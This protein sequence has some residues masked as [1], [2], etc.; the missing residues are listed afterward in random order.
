MY[1]IRPFQSSVFTSELNEQ[2][3][4]LIL[5]GLSI[6]DSPSLYQTI[7]DNRMFYIILYTYLYYCRSYAR[8]KKVCGVYNN[9]IISSHIL[10]FK[11]I[12]HYFLCWVRNAETNIIQVSQNPP[13]SFQSKKE[14]IA[15][16][17]HNNNKNN[18]VV[19]G[20]TNFYELGMA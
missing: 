14:V 2:L 17:T 12:F 6:L 3:I 9:F 15:C 4:T 11:L 19:K 18:S 5:F 20:K 10:T 13:E 1:N 16:K 8:K 7:P